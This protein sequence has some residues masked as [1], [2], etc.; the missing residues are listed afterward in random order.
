MKI[1]ILGAGAFGTALGGILAENGYDID[2]YDSRLEQERLSDVVSD[3][4]IVVVAVPSVSVP[5]LLPYLPKDKPLIIATKGILSDEA[6]KDFKDY[7]VISGPGFADD[8]KA[9]KKTR[10]TITNKRIEELFGRDYLVFDYTEDNNGV[11]MCGAL[12][13]VYAIYAGLKGLKRDSKDLKDYIKTASAEMKAV[14]KANGA[15]PKTVDCYCGIPDLIL[16]CGY[17]SRNYEFG[18][19][20]R[21]NPKYKAEKTVEGIS[22]LRRIRRGEIIVPD[23]AILLKELVEVSREWN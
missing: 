23:E 9:H 19:L 17:P 16:T 13:N 4:K 15:N 2:Y 7:M 18:D 21:N 1:A 12:K 11:L 10:L 6:F 5:Y 3:S 14:L 8:I 22:A 20:L